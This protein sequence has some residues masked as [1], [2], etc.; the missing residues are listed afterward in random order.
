MPKKHLSQVLNNT[1]SFLPRLSARCVNTGVVFLFVELCLL[2]ACFPKELRFLYCYSFHIM[3]THPLPALTFPHVF[4]A[5]LLFF[6]PSSFSLPTCLKASSSCH[7]LFQPSIPPC[8][9]TPPSPPSPP[10]PLPQTSAPP[11]PGS[12]VPL[13]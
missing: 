13:L 11:W 2:K 1:A 9:T 8:T 3:F 12:C 5:S 6:A 10:S 7:L 4:H